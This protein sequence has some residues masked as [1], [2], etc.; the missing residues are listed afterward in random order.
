M[1]RPSLFPKL[2]KEGLLE[3]P[4]EA[5]VVVVVVVVKRG[6]TVPNIFSDA[7]TSRHI[8]SVFLRHQEKSG[9][10]LACH[11]DVLSHRSLKTC[12]GLDMPDINGSTPA[13]VACQELSES[14]GKNVTDVLSE[15]NMSGGNLTLVDHEGRTPAHY[16]AAGKGNPKAIEFLYSLDPQAFDIRD[17]LNQTVEDMAEAAGSIV[18]VFFAKL[19]ADKLKL[20]ADELAN[21]TLR[22]ARLCSKLD[23][24]VHALF[25]C[26]EQVIKIPEGYAI[27][28]QRAICPKDDDE[29]AVKCPNP[30]A[31]PGGLYARQQCS[32]GYDV[33]SVGC[34][35][36]DVGFGRSNQDPFVCGQCGDIW[37]MW[38]VHLGKPVGIYILSL[39][40]AKPNRDLQSVLFNMLLSFCTVSASLW[41]A[42]KDSQAYH[43]TLPAVQAVVMAGAGTSKVNRLKRGSPCSSRLFIPVR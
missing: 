39:R 28:R 3:S 10:A 24:E 35:Q 11:Q 33:R 29:C 6:R 15:I 21:A 27:T 1:D 2:S 13:H 36:C 43:H 20:R 19:R 17:H 34:S 22:M 41:P 31:C 4:Y 12:R 23:K 25:D 14:T 5:V 32:A 7:T 8:L 38:T 42:I 37:Q 26:A 9:I 18:E 30:K 40:S 16:C